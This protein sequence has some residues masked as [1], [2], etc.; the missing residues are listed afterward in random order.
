MR[1]YSSQLGTRLRP[2]PKDMAT[3]RPNS[4]YTSATSAFLRAWRHRSRP[5]AIA[6]GASPRLVIM[7]GSSGRLRKSCVP[8]AR[9][10]RRLTPGT[11]VQ[12]I[13]RLA[14]T[15]GFVD[16]LVDLIPIPVTEARRWSAESGV[17]TDGRGDE[18]RC[19]S[20]VTPHRR[21][22]LLTLACRARAGFTDGCCDRTWSNTRETST[23]VWR[24]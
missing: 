18:H 1:K 15:A 10:I 9:H 7:W 21:A 6:G 16:N 24:A 20:M 5:T 13:S 8:P 19:W 4:T 17:G 3:Y 23:T 22:A 14:T 11:C 2:A 12:S